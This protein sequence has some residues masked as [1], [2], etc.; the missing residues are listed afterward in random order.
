MTSREP[1]ILPCIIGMAS[2]LDGCLLI[3]ARYHPKNILPTSTTLTD[4]KCTKVKEKII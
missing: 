4:G 2:C 3:F 1:G